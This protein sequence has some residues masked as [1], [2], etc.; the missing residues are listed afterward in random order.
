MS[1]A[2]SIPAR[3]SLTSSPAVRHFAA[4]GLWALG[5]VGV[6][7]AVYAVESLL[8][9]PR[10]AFLENPTEV[11]MRAFGLAHFVVGWMFL[12]SSPRLRS[13][14]AVSRLGLLTL[15][16]AGL[17]LLFAAG[18]ALRNP[19]L[20]LLFYGYFLVHE[21]RDE[22][23]LYRAY[24][25][26][27]PN[28]GRFLGA[29]SL[30]VAVLAAAAMVLAFS[31]HGSAVERAGRY[32]S[33]PH[34][35]L[36]L[37]VAVLLA[38]GVALAARALKVGAAVYGDGASALAA[39]RP[40]LAVYA[41]LFAI[42]LLGSLAGSAGFNLIILLHVCAWLVFVRSRLALRPGEVTGLWSWLRGT[43]AGF[44][45]LHLLV[46]GIILALMAARVHLWDRG[47]WVSELVATGNFPYWSLMHITMAFWHRR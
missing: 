16:G 23:E 26:A 14:A 31:L 27:G 10:R 18:G 13:P 22:A 20:L 44:V 12:F 40:L 43:P 28:A 47:G 45:T 2:P 15:L 34:V 9:R 7:C 21:I 37:I 24:D 36:P 41:A 11:M 46:A 3:A 35:V 29:L 1:L 32:T 25:G 39:H 19:F 42:L 33:A 38:L 17:C 8:L 6:G 30:A 4:A 5:A